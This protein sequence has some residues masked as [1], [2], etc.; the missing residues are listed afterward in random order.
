MRGEN[1][2]DL[3]NSVL[4]LTF[5]LPA[6]RTCRCDGNAASPIDETSRG[7]DAVAVNASGYDFQMTV[8]LA[9]WPVTTVHI[10]EPV[11]HTI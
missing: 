9:Q 3:S 5:K 7:T 2:L 6:H 8:T 1:I 10:H 4:S 11:N